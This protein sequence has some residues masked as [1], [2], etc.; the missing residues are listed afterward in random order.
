MA[1]KTKAQK[2]KARQKANAKSRNKARQRRAHQSRVQR[3]D[4]IAH[5]QGTLM[6]RKFNA[7]YGSACRERQDGWYEVTSGKAAGQKVFILTA[8]TIEWAN[9]HFGDFDEGDLETV[10]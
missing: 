8:E 2:R 7:E 5:I 6:R 10:A 1:K 3:D 9:K 4:M